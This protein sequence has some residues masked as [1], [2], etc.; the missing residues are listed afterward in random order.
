MIWRWMLL[1]PLWACLAAPAGADELTIAAYNVENFFDVY[2]DPYTNDGDPKE[3]YELERVASALRAIDADVVGFSEIE[4]TAVLD[5]L[6]QE[7]LPDMGYAYTTV[8][9]T[10]SQRGIHLGIASRYPVVSITSYRFNTLT[11]PG[12]DR[13]WRFARD[14]LHAVIDVNGIKVDVFVVHFKSRRTVSDDDP[15]SSTWRLAEATF[16]AALIQELLAEDPERLLTIMGDFNDELET[17][18][19]QALLRAG[20]INSH[21]D[22]PVEEQ[23]TYLNPPYRSQ[24]DF[25]FTSPT[26]AAATV[27]AE[28]ISDPEL[29]DGSDHAPVTLTVDLP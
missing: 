27:S 24:I 20:L 12:D 2:D 28:I 6:I 17:P 7:Y 29:T 3:T 21:A 11:L 9:P 4:N 16:T 26:L 22:V 14:L 1:V 5:A 15:R 25:I 10:N 19:I 18:T 13:Q 23:I 8:Q